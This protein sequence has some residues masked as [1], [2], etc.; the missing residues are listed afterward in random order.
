VAAI[1]TS[2]SKDR[3]V[4]SLE[5]LKFCIDSKRKHS[6]GVCDVNSQVYADREYRWS[7][8]PSVLRGQMMVSPACDDRMTRLRQYIEFVPSQSC[9]VFILLDLRNTVPSWIVSDGFQR[10][11]NM[12][13]I[14]RLF[15]YT[16]STVTSATATGISIASHYGIHAKRFDEQ[17]SV[18]LRGNHAASKSINMYLAFVVP[19]HSSIAG[20]KEVNFILDINNFLTS[21]KAAESWSTG[22]ESVSLCT[23]ENDSVSIGVNKD[24]AFSDQIKIGDSYPS[25]GSFEVVDWKTRKAFQLT[26]S[27]HDAQVLH[28]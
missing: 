4:L 15:G 3:S 22:G 7:Y 8:L 11:P 9:I 5:L 16:S 12:H 17:E 2:P 21:D 26:Y 6:V 13:A 1:A 10:I 20:I 19:N 24:S 25:V 18:T 23:P 27:L 14:C 28:H